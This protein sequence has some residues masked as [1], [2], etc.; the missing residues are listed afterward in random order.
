MTSEVPLGSPALTT[1]ALRGRAVLRRLA[2]T[3]ARIRP[4]A[5]GLQS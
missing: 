2:K 1:G 4:Q 5:R 3:I